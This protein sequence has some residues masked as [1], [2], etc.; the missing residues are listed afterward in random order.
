[1][2]SKNCQINEPFENNRKI[3]IIDEEECMVGTGLTSFKDCVWH[4]SP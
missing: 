3:R 2:F 1:M 4:D